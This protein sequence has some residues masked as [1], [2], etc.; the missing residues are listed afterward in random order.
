MTMQWGVRARVMLVAVLPMLVVALLLTAFYTSSRLEDIE[1]A[2]IARGKAYARQLVAASEYA[3]FSGNHDALQ[4]LTEE[5]PTFKVIYNK[6]T[7]QTVVSGMGELH[8]E[9]IV[10]RLLSEFKVGAVVGKPRVA[11]KETITTSVQ[12]EGKFVR[13]SGGHGQYGHV[14]LE[15]EPGE[16]G[17]GFSSLT[18]FGVTPYRGS[19]YPLLRTA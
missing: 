17:S 4:K 12:A 18:L 2:H 7:G 15:L 3:V 10:N 19:I 5:D 6:E 8:L 11:Y 13:Q 14:R 1:E 16:S 9:V